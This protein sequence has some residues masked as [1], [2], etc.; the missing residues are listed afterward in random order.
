[1][2]STEELTCEG[3]RVGRWRGEGSMTRRGPLDGISSS[4]PRLPK[5]AQRHGKKCEGE[6]PIEKPH[7]ISLVVYVGSIYYEKKCISLNLDDTFR[8]DLPI[9]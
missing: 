6:F 3:A 2:T 1:M 9:L 4:S 7:G 8:S 5:Q